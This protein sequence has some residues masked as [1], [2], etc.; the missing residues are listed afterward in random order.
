MLHVRGEARGRRRQLD[1]V[2][3]T[4]VGGS[5]KTEEQDRELFFEI[6]SEQQ[7]MVGGASIV[8][9]CSRQAEDGS[10]R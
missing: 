5:T 9:G 4:S 1:D 8:D 6:W 10:G 3:R 2:R 7:N